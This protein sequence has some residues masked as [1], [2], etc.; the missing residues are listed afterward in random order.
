[1]TYEQA[2]YI[3]LD[4]N[5]EIYDAGKLR[6]SHPIPLRHNLRLNAFL[7]TSAVVG[8][9]NV[10]LMEFL[11]PGT[12]TNGMFVLLTIG[13]LIAPF[14]SANLPSRALRIIS[15]IHAKKEAT[16]EELARKFRSLKNDHFSER[17]AEILAK[18]TPAMDFI[19]ALITSHNQ[20]IVYSDGEGYTDPHFAV[21]TTIHDNFTCTVSLG[22]MDE[23]SME[24]LKRRA[25]DTRKPYLKR[26]SRELNS[27]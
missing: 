21:E 15:P 18:A 20:K 24:A 5:A 27:R 6:T 23:M 22:G 9:T 12:M 1:M 4:C 17:E 13:S 7:K 2:V 25:E 26:L 19:N 14:A 3:L 11:P 16:H 10:S 8:T